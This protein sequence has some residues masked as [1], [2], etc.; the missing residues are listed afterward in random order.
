MALNV[1]APQ[2]AVF[3][4]EVEAAH[5]APAALA[6]LGSSRQ[7]RVAHEE[8]GFSSAALALGKLFV[9]LRSL[10]SCRRVRGIGG[11]SNAYRAEDEL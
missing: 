9:K 6:S 11:R 4:P 3:V 5:G 7:R 10:D 8:V 2:L 1:A